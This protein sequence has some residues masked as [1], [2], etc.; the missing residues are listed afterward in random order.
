DE[1]FGS[2]PAN[3][4]LLGVYMQGLEGGEDEQGD[5]GGQEPVDEESAKPNNKLKAESGPESG[6]ADGK[7][8]DNLKKFIEEQGTMSKSLGLPEMSS[9]KAWWS[10]D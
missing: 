3:P 6:D 9:I 8:L 2:A 7:E 10:N 4:S 5:P 1:K